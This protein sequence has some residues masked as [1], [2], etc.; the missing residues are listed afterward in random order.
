LNFSQLAPTHM[1]E[2]WGT[3]TLDH[4]GTAVITLPGYFEAQTS[5]EQRSVLLTSEGTV[6]SQL[7]YEP[8][9][10]GSLTVHGT[11]GTVFSWLVKAVRIRIVLGVDSGAEQVA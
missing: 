8:I 3:S 10:D 7:S 1:V 2:Y 6:G 11:A 5:P 4:A 9:I